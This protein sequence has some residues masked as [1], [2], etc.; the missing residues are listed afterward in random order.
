MLNIIRSFFYSV[1]LLTLYWV[2][3]HPADQVTLA[4]WAL[5]VQSEHLQQACYIITLTIWAVDNTLWGLMAWPTR[6]SCWVSVSQVP[7]AGRSALFTE[8]PSMNKLDK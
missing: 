8:M 1:A 7:R 4:A 2:S 3:Q 6:T 5:A